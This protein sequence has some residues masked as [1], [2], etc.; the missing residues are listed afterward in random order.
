MSC[1]DIEALAAEPRGLQPSADAVRTP[2]Q[3][4]YLKY[5]EYAEVLSRIGRCESGMRQ[6]EEDGSV[7]RGKVDKNDTGTYQINLRFWGE[8]AKELGYDLETIEGN[9]KM[10][11]Y[12]Y[13]HKGTSPWLPS[14]SFSFS[15]KLYSGL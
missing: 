4:L 2:K 10:A 1:C 9:T 12:I 14:V 5:P 11:V 7:L 13:E 3:Y 8:K 15:S 6:F